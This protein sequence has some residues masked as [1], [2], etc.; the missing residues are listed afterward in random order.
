MCLG[1]ANTMLYEA[2]QV[3]YSLS[4]STLPSCSHCPLSTPLP[5]AIIFMLIY[6]HFLSYNLYLF[7]N[8][9]CDK[10]CILF[11]CL[12]TFKFFIYF[13]WRL[14]T[15]QYCGGFFPYIDMNHPGRYMCPPILNLPPT[16][17][18]T[19]PFWVVPENQL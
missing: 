15:L 6:I 8:D 3:A 2:S 17:L 13:N 4:D 5:T 19:P 7:D 18:P 10:N 16:S 11:V 9:G 12:L 14:I 1:P